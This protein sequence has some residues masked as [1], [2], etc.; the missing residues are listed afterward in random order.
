MHVKDLETLKYPELQKLAKS[1]GI[2]ANQKIDKLIKAL[3]DHFIET[4]NEE[5][6]LKSPFKPTVQLLQSSKTNGNGATPAKQNLHPHITA[7]Q[8]PKLFSPIAKRIIKPRSKAQPCTSQLAK[9]VTN[10]AETYQTPKTSAP[11]TPDRKLIKKRRRTFELETP[12]LSPKSTPN[13]DDQPDKRIKTQAE[14][15]QLTKQDEPSKKR[16]RRNTFDK[17]SPSQAATENELVTTR[18]TRSSVSPSTKAI[19]DSI[20]ADLSSAERKAMLMS[21]ID[22]KVQREKENSASLQTT[23]NQSTSQIPRF[24]AF[25]ANKKKTDEHKPA[26]PGSKNWTKIHK[27]EFSKFDSLDVYLEKKQ[28]RMETLTGSAK[29]IPLAKSP[30]VSGPKIV[31]PV[32]KPLAPVK[33][34]VPTVTSTRNL[35][36]NFTKTPSGK[37]NANEKI[38]NLKT[39]KEDTLVFS[40]R[41]SGVP[42]T[43]PFK[44]TGNSTTLNASVASQK[45]TFD[46][47]ASLAKPLTWRPHTGKLQP[48]DVNKTLTTTAKP[49]VSQDFRKTRQSRQALASKSRPTQAKDVRRVQQLDR[50]NNQKYIDMMKRRGLMS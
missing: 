27:K 21:A 5:D 31:K 3:K 35:S 38:V 49:V 9:S 24:M 46:L 48:L 7:T 25:L 13:S 34:F 40:A 8:S 39:P 16:I 20:N 47:K 6:T 42:S 45:K 14:P 41:K 26:T 19:I 15:A 36:F 12:T 29:K 43:T 2:K 37:G 23:T 50:R 30:K 28:Q 22:K 17:E 32:T 10:V 18:T 44:F 11:S 33:P 4:E 1:V